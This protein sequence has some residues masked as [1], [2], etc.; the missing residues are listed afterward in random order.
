VPVAECNACDVWRSTWQISRERQI[1]ADE[2]RCGQ[3]YGPLRWTRHWIRP[4]GQRIGRLQKS[5]G[6]GWHCQA[7][8]VQCLLMLL[9]SLSVQFRCQCVVCLVF[10]LSSLLSF[11]D[12]LS[13][14][15]RM[16]V[17]CFQ[18]FNWKHKN[19]KT[20]PFKSYAK[21]MLLKCFFATLIYQTSRV[22]RL[23]WRPLTG[24]LTV[25]V[26]GRNMF[27]HRWSQCSGFV[28]TLESDGIINRRFC[29]FYFWFE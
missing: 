9:N 7:N 25:S 16:N 12:L 26:N 17:R 19:R 23:A 27:W 28:Q 2:R 4:A 20:M 6:T 18:A 29:N 3:W 10:I 14:Y 13:T 1:S 21:I 5:V 24:P 11:T 8:A 15:N 22:V